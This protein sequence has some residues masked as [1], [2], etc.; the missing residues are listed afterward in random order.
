MENEER[1]QLI[2]E[3]DALFA[4]GRIDDALNAYSAI[5]EQDP[6]V[7]WAHSRIGAIFAQKGDLDLA[8]QALL[9]ALELDP[10]LPQAH[11]NLGNIHY[12]RGEYDQAVERYQTA[13]KLDPNNPLY[14]ENL[15]AAYKKQ[16]KL[17]EAVKA[18]KHSH[19]LVRQNSTQ[20]TKSEFQNLKRKVGCASV[21]VI[22][23]LMIGV[24]I[25]VSTLF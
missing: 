15:H 16:K 18:L 24:V 7:A 8:E 12:T 20:Q 4:R 3:A 23:V 19:K 6:T 25:G 17:S 22:T 21:L 9:K 10:E 11:S 2:K 14:H 13:S 1:A 5:L